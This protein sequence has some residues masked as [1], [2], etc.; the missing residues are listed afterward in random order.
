MSSEASAPVPLPRSLPSRGGATNST[1]RSSSRSSSSS[2]RRA[3][4]DCSL[5]NVVKPVERP[6]TC[7]APAR[8]TKN[9][10]RRDPASAGAKAA[11]VTLVHAAPNCKHG[12][13][14]IDSGASQHVTCEQGRLTSPA[15]TGATT[16]FLANGVSVPIEGVG[17]VMLPEFARPLKDIL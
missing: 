3:L 11:Q 10:L 14:Q 16:V 1:S 9:H 2:R 13:W 4:Q 17:S 7:S 5:C 15:A 12:T 8:L 6:P